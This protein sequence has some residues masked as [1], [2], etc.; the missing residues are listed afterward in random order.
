VTTS[1]RHAAP[2]AGP[3]LLLIVAVSL[4]GLA[5]LA[6]GVIGL[7]R[8]PD[9]DRLL[10][11]LERALARSGRPLEGGVTLAALEQRFRDTPAAAEYVRSLRLARYAGTPSQPTAAQRRALRQRLGSG[12]GL[13]G[14]L[15]ALWA[16]PPRSVLSPRTRSSGLKS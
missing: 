11:E 15:R 5:V 9:E 16:L 12:L 3:P 14:R 1:R 4:G 7:R 8:P 2:G 13:T 6:L 10:A